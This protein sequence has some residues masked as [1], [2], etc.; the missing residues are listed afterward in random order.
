MTR[1][2]AV[3]GASAAGFVQ[4]ASLQ[5]TKYNLYSMFKDDEYVL[6][7]DPDKVYPEMMSGTN[8]AFFDGLQVLSSV[9]KRWME[10]YADAKDCHGYKYIGWGQSDK[11]FQLSFHSQT[12]KFFDI[13]MFRTAM[14]K[15]GG[16][17][18]GDGVKIIEEKIDSVLINPDA[19]IINGVNYD[20][21][22]DLSLIHI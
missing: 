3:V 15:D 22:I 21:V 13:E 20:Y 17:C 14:V 11:N 16:K 10:K 18:F 4:L 19:A 6:I 8:P 2:I 9:T 5:L 1:K 7:H 12:A